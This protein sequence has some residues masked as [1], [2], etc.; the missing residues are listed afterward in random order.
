MSAEKKDEGA[1]TPVPTSGVQPR[2]QRQ[3]EWPEPKG[4][5]PPRFRPGDVVIVVLPGE[6][7]ERTAVVIGPLLPGNA[8][9]ETYA[10]IVDDVLQVEAYE[11]WMRG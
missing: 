1:A 3:A 5:L 10:V 8:L 9:V 6:E 11:A 4:Y 2:A 7:V